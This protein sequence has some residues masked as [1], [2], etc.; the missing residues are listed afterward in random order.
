MRAATKAA[1][2]GQ[3]MC[4]Q[5]VPVR[6]SEIMKY[7]IYLVDSDTGRLTLEGYWGSEHMGFDD[8]SDAKQAVAELQIAWPDTE[9]EIRKLPRELRAS[10]W[11]AELKMW[12]TVSE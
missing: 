6:A 5:F 3:R 9:W 7:Q 4:S 12:V 11:S 8:L 2:I 1:K 10:Y